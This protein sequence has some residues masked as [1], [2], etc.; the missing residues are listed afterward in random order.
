MN[1]NDLSIGGYRRV[2]QFDPANRDKIDACKALWDKLFEKPPGGA[3]RHAD[4]H[5]LTGPVLYLWETL[6]SHE[7]RRTGKDGSDD[8][9]R[10]KLQ[11]TR[12]C[13]TEDSLAAQ[14]AAGAAASRELAVAPRQVLGAHLHYTIWADVV[15]G[16]RLATA[17]ACSCPHS[18]HLLAPLG[19]VDDLEHGAGYGGAIDGFEQARKAHVSA[20]PEK[21]KKKA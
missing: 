5:I 21:G 2:S 16:A 8:K 17:R 7:V 9:P 11:I 20:K 10:A 18:A 12:A 13:E 1:W 6:V 15:R 14:N 3:T 19:Q 4:Y